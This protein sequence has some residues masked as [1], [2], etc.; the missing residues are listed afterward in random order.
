[1]SS[2]TSVGSRWRKL[3]AG[4]VVSALLVTGISVMVSRKAAPAVAFTTIGGESLTSADLRGKV[5]LVNFWATSCVTCVAEMPMLVQTHRQ[6]ASRGYE[7]V[8]IAMSYDRL[9]YVDRFSTTRQLPFKVTFDADDK[10]ASS[11]DGV[12]ATPTSFLLDRKGRIAKRFVGEID[13]AELASAIQSEL[14]KS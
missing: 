12:Q 8:A 6:F 3:L 9:D 14:A 7:T 4:V 13:Q 2:L 1:M 11:F 5:V 10:L